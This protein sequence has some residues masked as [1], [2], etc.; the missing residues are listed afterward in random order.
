MLETVAPVNV[1]VQKGTDHIYWCIVTHNNLLVHGVG[2]WVKMLICKCSFY[3][4]WMYTLQKARQKHVAERE[5]FWT[6]RMMTYRCRSEDEGFHF[7]LAWF[8]PFLLPFVVAENLFFVNCHQSTSPQFQHAIAETSVSFCGF[9]AV[10]QPSKPLHNWCFAEIIPPSLPSVAT[11][12]PRPP[13]RR[14]DSTDFKMKQ[15]PPYRRL[16]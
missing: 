14:K 9:R 16:A 5:R 15:C 13:S 10:S 11:N 2:S 12:N 1:F 3:P 6:S 4:W 8:L 7:S